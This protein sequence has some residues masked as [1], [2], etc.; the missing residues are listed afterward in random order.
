MSPK[1]VAKVDQLMALVDQLETQ[2]AAAR[3]TAAN[4]IEASSS[5]SPPAPTSAHEHHT[6]LKSA[7]L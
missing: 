5:N 1:I 3:A 2:L 6:E 4:P 7:K